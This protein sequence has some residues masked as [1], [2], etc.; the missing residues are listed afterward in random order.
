MLRIVRK[1]PA[2]KNA[3]DEAIDQCG[4]VFNIRDAIE[5]A[6]IKSEQ[7]TDDRT[8]KMYAQRGIQ[9]LRRYFELI[10]FAAYLQSTE[11]DTISTSPSFEG[12]VKSLPV[13]K[14]FEKELT[15]DGM[16]ALRP[17]VRVD[18]GDGVALPDEVSAVVSN[19]AGEVLSQSTILK[20]D[21]FSNLQ[22]MSLPE[23]ALLAHRCF[24]TLKQFTFLLPKEDRWLTKLPSCALATPACEV[25]DRD[26][27]NSA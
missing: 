25:W 19:R 11:P 27:D 13:L 7:A 1:G 15:A 4:E 23:C 14:T 16:A 3:V 26:S 5:E 12:F 17:L 20:S 9:N 6:R 22:K 8:K 21:F 2:I 10:V 24:C 18:I